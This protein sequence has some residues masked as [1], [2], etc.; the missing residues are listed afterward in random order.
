ML[1][2]TLKNLIANKV[3]FALTTFGVMLAVSFVVAALVLGDGL[4]STFGDIAEDTTA[5]IDL[6]VRPEADF[7]EP[8]P[9]PAELLDIVADVEGVQDVAPKLE[10]PWDVVQLLDAEGVPLNLGGPPHIGFAWTDN[11]AFSAFSLVEGSSPGVGQF[12]VDHS[13]ATNH[14]LEIGESYELTT[15]SGRLTLELSGT[16][17]FGKENGT[18]G[19]IL[20]QVNETEAAA[21]FGIDGINSVN[22]QVVDGHDIAQVQAAIQDVAP[23]T[24]VVGNDVVLAEAGEDLLGEVNL[25]G[26]ILLGFGFIALFVSSFIIYNTFAIVLGQRIQELGLLRTIGADPRQIQRSVLGEAL[27]VGILASV[28]GLLLGVAMTVGL[29]AL[30][31]AIGVNVTD[32]PTIVT[33]RTIAIA[34]FV[35]VGVT[36]LAAV[37]PS[38]R[39]S[40]VP[41]IAALRGGVDAGGTKLGT[42]LLGGGGLLGVGLVAGIVGL[43]S[44][45]TSATVTFMAVGAFSIV[46]GVALLSP[47]VVGI[48][49]AVIGWPITKISG[50]AGRLAAQNAGR[51]PQRT[52]TTAAALMIGLALVSAVMIVGESVKGTIAS[53]VEDSAFAD[54]YLSD[55][56]DEVVFPLSTSDDLKAIDIVESVVGFRLVETR[57]NGEIATNSATSFA[58]I[59]ATFDLDLRE[60]SYDLA[61]VNPVVISSDHAK[62][63]KL[64]IGDVVS[65][66]FANGALV[67]ATIVGIFHDRTLVGADY[68]FDESVFEGAGDT[69]GYETLAISLVDGADPAAVAIKVDALKAEFPAANIETKEEFRERSEGVID[70]ILAMAN[71]LVALAVLIA[72]IGIA[73]TLAL[74]V[75][76]RTRE[77]GLLRAV[78]MTPR[79]LRRMVRLEAGLVA[80]FGAVL[81]TII[82]AVFGWAIVAAM[83]DSLA[84]SLT[85]PGLAIGVLVLVAAFAGVVAATL[86]ARRAG[87]LNVLDAISR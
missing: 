84:A 39:A 79:Q 71:V 41:A 53:S 62:D 31:N 80:A 72:L 56:F 24:E 37:G 43:A 75:F 61:A 16:S 64:D 2:I 45:G 34:I 54:Y 48:V 7:G 27:V 14:E 73:N 22:V 47:L 50:L 21:M 18:A 44:S 15:P 26:N 74:S 25:I 87:K 46:L 49:T 12:V 10:A 1:Q 78:G 67:E 63:S 76:E 30:F 66:E 70:D 8:A 55:E 23:G 35:G 20:L 6:Q 86:P 42:R 57:V 82:G 69:K 68:L 59:E 81:G 85:V 11:D 19:A 32:V 28:G 40:S 4:R 36:M 17:S 58:N 33:P 83:P 13:S 9:L 5:G 3:R 52:A 65:T 60:G 51:N 29:V 38:R 77:L